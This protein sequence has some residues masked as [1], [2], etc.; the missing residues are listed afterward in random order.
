MDPLYG[1][2]EAGYITVREMNCGN[3]GQDG[4][5][6]AIR[7]GDWVGVYYSVVLG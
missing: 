2:I 6:S 5:A 4:E 1:I 3:Q 7:I